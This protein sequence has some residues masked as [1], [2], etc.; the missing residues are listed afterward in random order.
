MMEKLAQ[1]GR[2]RGCTPTPFHY[3][4]HHVQSCESCG[5]R[6]SW[7][8]KYTPPISTPPLFVLCS[9]HCIENNAHSLSH[10][11]NFTVIPNTLLP[12]LVNARQLITR[13][14]NIGKFMRRKAFVLV[15]LCTWQDSWVSLERSVHMKNFP[16]NNWTPVAKIYF[17]LK[18]IGNIMLC[19]SAAYNF[20]S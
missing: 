8:D 9:I 17:I 5:V 16:L 13:S 18:I 2:G 19:I 1:A 6:S 3:I 10:I 12:P 4:Y 20:Y 7:V 15:R 14:A 11:V